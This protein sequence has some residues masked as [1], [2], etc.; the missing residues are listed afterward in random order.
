M[1]NNDSQN[2]N[3]SGKLKPFE[4]DIK[5]R[6][7]FEK[8]LAIFTKNVNSLTP[9]T[10]YGLSLK[11]E[12]SIAVQIT[13]EPSFLSPSEKQEREIPIIIRSMNDGNHI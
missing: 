1:D 9:Y 11:S 13:M 8:Q 10:I 6:A 2:L 5:N 12:F 4:E 3:K 7:E